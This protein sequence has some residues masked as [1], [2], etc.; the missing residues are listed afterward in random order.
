MSLEQAFLSDIVEHPDDDAPRLIFA[1]WLDEQGEADRA[2]LI[3]LQIERAGLDA[4]DPAQ[5]D[6]KAREVVLLRRCKDAVLAATG[7]DVN[8]RK[9]PVEWT[10]CRGFPEGC[11]GMLAA[12]LIHHAD[13]LMQCVPLRELA[14]AAPRSFAPELARCPLL[15][16]V[17]RLRLRGVVYNPLI[18]GME[19]SFLLASNHLAGLRE[20]D[21][22]HNGLTGADL[23]RLWSAPPAQLQALDL[24]FNRLDSS[25]MQ[26]L[27]SAPLDNLRALSL[28]HATDDEGIALLAESSRLR[29]VTDLYLGGCLSANSTALQRLAQRSTF[30]RLQRLSLLDNR[31]D[32]D[33]ARALAAWPG[34][35]RLQFARPFVLEA[36][37]PTDFPVLNNLRVLEL[38]GHSLGLHGL[39]V[40]LGALRQATLQAVLLSD[41]HL[42]RKVVQLLCSWPGLATVH[43][44]TLRSTFIDAQDV[45][46]LARSPHLAAIRKLD[47]GGNPLGDAGLLPLFEA[48]WLGQLTEL[49]LDSSNMGMEAARALLRC[50]HLDGLVALRLGKVGELS[51]RISQALHERFA[52]VLC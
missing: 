50:P 46:A 6:L 43:T 5:P 30:P 37:S 14:P 27:A 33:A 48:P 15:A 20:L 11:R 4:D 45:A 36:F 22:A 3:R 39:T 35:R 25:A 44:L 47:L 26:R 18:G 19:L 8:L 1:D 23:D 16:R 49:Y 10:F 29:N 2:A 28:E 24:G 41:I 40:L 38:R 34:L 12:T 13:H 51:T 17:R 9:P 42:S 31:L 32:A 7:L 21:L 52:A